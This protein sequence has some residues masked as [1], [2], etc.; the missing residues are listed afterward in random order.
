MTLIEM[1]VELDS[2]HTALNLDLALE[3]LE[4]L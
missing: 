4:L 3:R 2:V 1:G